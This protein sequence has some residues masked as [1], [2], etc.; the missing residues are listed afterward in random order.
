MN[1][2]VPSYED[3]IV[4]GAGKELVDF[5]GAVLLSID[6]VDCHVMFA[7]GDVL[8]CFEFQ[9]LPHS[10]LERMLSWLAAHF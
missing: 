6:V 7:P 8:C 5:P 4:C 9:L 3:I 10:G 1:I 2:K